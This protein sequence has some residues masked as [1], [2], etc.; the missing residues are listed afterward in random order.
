MRWWRKRTPQ[1]SDVDYRQIAEGVR[2]RRKSRDVLATRQVP[3][4]ATPPPRCTEVLG[5]VEDLVSVSK[6]VPKTWRPE[7]WLIDWERA[8][9]LELLR[10]FHLAL[11]YVCV[12]AC[13]VIA[14]LV[15]RD[16]LRIPTIA[17]VG[18]SV[19]GLAGAVVALRAAARSQDRMLWFLVIAIAVVLG[20]TT[21][22]MVRQPG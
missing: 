6:S 5:A 12:P 9:N 13:V 20:V 8:N 21:A 18:V 15:S 4:L 16:A 11:F 3:I 10:T 14:F 1:V 7:T 2:D 22:A 17:F 19:L